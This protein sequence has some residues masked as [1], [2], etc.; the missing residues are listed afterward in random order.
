MSYSRCIVSVVFFL[1]VAFACRKEAPPC[2]TCPPPYVQTVFLDTLSVDVTEVLLRVRA[3]D[4]SGA[5]E[6]SVYRDSVPVFTGQPSR[7]DTTLLDTALAPGR[8][9]SYKAYRLQNTQ[10]IDSV[11]LAVRTMDTTSHN[12]TWRIEQLGDGAS[13]VLRDVFIIDQNNVWAAGE[14]YLRDSS[15]QFDPLPYNVAHW[16]GTDWE[17]KRATVIFRGNSVTP[18]LEGVFAFSPTDI[19]LVGSLPIHGDGQ[20]WT[21]FDLRAMPGLDSVSVSRAW[22]TNSSNMYF[23]GLNGTI[24]HYNGTTWQ[25]IESGTTLDVYDIWG[26]RNCS[27]G[28]HEVFAVAAKQFVS[29]EKEI[30]RVSAITATEVPVDSIPY[31]LQGIWFRPGRHYYVVGSGMYAKRSIESIGPWQWLHPG[32]TQYY[33]YAIRG[34]QLN[35]FVVCGS[36]GEVL[37]F[38]GVTWKSFRDVTG[39]AQGTYYGIALRENLIVAVGYDSPRAIVARGSR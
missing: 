8:L 29:F 2:L 38:N 32:V 22:G 34:T 30:F 39:I 4:T 13:S 1:L 31:S 33:T 12:F 36:F 10:R 20:S 15:G 27:T 35:D 24:V 7:G 23:V 21:I 19:W 37:H 17:L 5:A 11:V 18:P 6:V 14:I 26:D 28:Q 9:Y 25:R 3:I 16:N